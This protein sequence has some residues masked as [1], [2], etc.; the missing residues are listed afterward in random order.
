MNNESPPETRSSAALGTVIKPWLS[1]GLIIALAGNVLL[2]A[3][4]IVKLSGFEDM[5]RRADETEAEAATKRTEL[6]S[7]QVDVE[8]LS[9]QKDA[10][11]PTVADWEK[12]LKE[13]ATAEAAMVNLEAKQQQAESDVA[14]AAKHLEEINRN[15]LKSEKQKTELDSAIEKFKSE[16]L[17]LTKSN[18]D[19]NAELSLAAEAERRLSNATNGVANADAARKQFEADA[20]AAQAR[21]DQLQKEGDNLRQTRETLNTDAATLRQQ[22]QSLK[23]Q[24]SSFDKQAAELK[25]LQSAVQQEEQK[26]AKVQQQLATAE[27][28]AGEMDNRQRQAESELTQL[29]NR[30][31]Q[32]RS[33]TAEWETKRDTAQQAAIKATQELAAA[34]KLLAETQA[35]QDQRAREQVTLVAQIAASKTDLEQARKDAADADARLDTANAALQKA[36]ADLAGVRKFSQEL[37]TKQGELTREVSRL[38]TTVE[39]LKKEREALEKQL[40]RQDAQHQK[41][42]TE[43]QK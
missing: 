37:S 6:S 24:L 29:T 9:K 42:P 11:A 13:K 19:A 28:R 5:K 43:G 21:F 32:A 25:A 35:S 27:A 15:V 10:L 23:D 17:T 41:A 39:Q 2:S 36:D 40:G 22:L 4:L 26:L 20:T 14:Q 38:E 7:L 16:L 3:I 34:Q 8:S 12:R 33:Q 18:T 31:D 30:L 1:A